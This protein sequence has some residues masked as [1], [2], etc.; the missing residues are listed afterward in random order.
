ME[1]EV[2]KILKEKRVE[3][4]LIK[5]TGKTITHEDVIK[6][7]DANPEDDCK[8]IIIEGEK[9]NLFAFFLRGMM[10]ID[11]AKAKKV[12]GQKIS[13]IDPQRLKEV[14]GRTQGAITPIL[15]KNFKIFID[16]RVFGREKIQFSSGHPEY[17]LELYTKD[18]GNIMD[19]EKADFAKQ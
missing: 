5:L 8:T 2:E 18:L 6:H 7:S 11:F 16:T 1:L 19:F 13:I 15:L 4:R 10:K 9:S 12:A 14:T 17:G 3:Y